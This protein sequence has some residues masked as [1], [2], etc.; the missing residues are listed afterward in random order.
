MGGGG[1]IR[2][3]FLT[4]SHRGQLITTWERGEAALLLAQRFGLFFPPSCFL[5]KT[6]H[7]GLEKRFFLGGKMP[8]TKERENLAEVISQWNSD[9][10]DLFEIS[11]PDEVRSVRR[12]RNTF[13]QQNHLFYLDLLNSCHTQSVILIFIDRVIQMIY[14]III[15][16]NVKWNILITVF[17]KLTEGES[18]H[19]VYFFN[20]L[21]VGQ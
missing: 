15:G 14:I 17:I 11:Q 7:A 2:R 18:V 4:A 16:Q 1:K 3:L 9:R 6:L 13:K 5:S 10:L 21:T 20:F 8:E 12:S 19:K